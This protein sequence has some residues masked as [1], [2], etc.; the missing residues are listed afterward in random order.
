M[1]RLTKFIATVLVFVLA[2][3]PLTVFNAGAVEFPEGITREQTDSVIPKLNTLIKTILASGGKDTDIKGMLY[4][5]LYKDETV[6]AIFSAIYSALGEN[7]DALSVIGVSITPAALTKALYDYPSISRKISSC[8]DISAVIAASESFK[9]DIS[10]KKDFGKALSAMLSPFNALL[11]ALLC[12]GKVS[13]NSFLAIQGDDGYQNAI[14]PLLTAIDCPEIMTSSDFAASAA[15]NQSNIIKNIVSM[16][17]SAVDKLLDAPV[18]GLTET[19]PKI[20][21]YLDSGKLT[22]SITALLEPISLKVAG[23]LTIPGIAQLIT[24]AADLEGSLNIDEMLE[25]LDLF[26]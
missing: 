11:N 18:I 16:A 2:F 6:N 25:N 22:A 20:A 13:I 21:L 7:A 12:S 1:K 8:A 14:V 5:T 10:S 3:S 19:L 23:I 15:K 26:A 17:F 4:D 24:S 9:W